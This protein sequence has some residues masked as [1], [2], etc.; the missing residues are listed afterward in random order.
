MDRRYVMGASIAAALALLPNGAFAQQ[1]SIKDQLVGAWTLLLIDGIDAEGMHR[2][3]YGPNPE[4]ILINTPNG[5][6]AVE[7]MRTINRPRF[8]SNNR[9]T[10][11]AEENKA[12]VQGALAYFGTYTVDEAGKM[13]LGRIEGSTFPN[14]EGTRQALKIVEITDEVMTLDG[15]VAQSSIPGASGIKTIEA[16]WKKIK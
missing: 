16:I 13:L 14:A 15:P 5:H 10:G 7:F 4:G 11:T 8:A 12:A 1:K 9:D 2:P 6:Y 3:L